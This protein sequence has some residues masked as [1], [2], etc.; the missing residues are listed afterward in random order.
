LVLDVPLGLSKEAFEAYVG[1]Q[2][3]QMPII[4]Q[5]DE[6]VGEPQRFGAVTAFLKQQLIGNSPDF[7]ANSAWQ[8]LMRWL[9]YFLPTRYYRSVPNHSE[10]FSRKLH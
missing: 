7:S 3:L 8:T 10:V 2:L 5:V 6:F 1:A 4:R 9:M